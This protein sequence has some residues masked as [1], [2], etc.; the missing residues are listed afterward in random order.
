MVNKNHVIEERE[1]TAADLHNEHNDIPLP[2][3][4]DLTIRAIFETA[5]NTDQ[6]KPS[7]EESK[8]KF[9]QYS[10][11]S[12][13]CQDFTRQMIL[14]NG[15]EPSNPKA[16]ELLEPQDGKALIGSLG[17]LAPVAQAITDT[18]ATLDRVVHGDGIKP[19]KL[20]PPRHNLRK[21]KIKA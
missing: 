12:D 9:V 2:A 16:Q 17:I 21:V 13:N 7:S 14:D 1:A 15:L 4:H 18:A 5:M 8:V 3:D 20:R 10:G 6:G 19:Y 11:H